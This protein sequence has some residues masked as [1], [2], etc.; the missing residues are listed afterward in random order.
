MFGAISRIA[1]YN[2]KYKLSRRGRK[3]S[4]FD[5]SKIIMALPKDI[6][7]RTWVEI[8][9]KE[10]NDLFIFD[11]REEIIENAL[12]IGHSHYMEIQTIT[13]TVHCAV[14]A[15]LKLIDWNF[16][17]HDPGEDVSAWPPCFIPKRAESWQP[18]EPPEPSPRDAYCRQSLVIVE[19]E[20]KE[21]LPKCSSSTSLYYP[22]VEEIPRECW[23]P[24]KVNLVSEVENVESNKVGGMEK[25][26]GNGISLR[27]SEENLAAESEVLQKIIDYS[28]EQVLT[29]EESPKPRRIDSIETTISALEDKSKGLQ[30]CEISTLEETVSQLKSQILERDQDLLA[31]DIQIAGF[32]ETSGENTAHII[33]AIAK[34]LC[35][36][37][38][39]RDVVSS[40][41]TGFIRDNGEGSS[42]P[43]P[44]LLVV[45]LSRRAQRDTL[46][47]AARVRRTRRGCWF[48]H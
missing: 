29:I 31:N 15:W 24:G 6:P 1:F 38:D 42:V 48:L 8:L 3:L 41:R 35:V 19:D 5:E 7:D 10:E 45:R 47:Q 4:N 28:T 23:F 22:I 39:E 16:Y 44:R 36:D 43:R 32:P 21:S 33:L 40:E 11:I 18:D 13:F 34:K 37:L 26:E 30:G 20:S 46:I 25:F 14:K 27:T 17:R 2:N 9:Q 12:R